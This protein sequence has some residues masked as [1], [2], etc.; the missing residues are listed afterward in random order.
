LWPRTGFYAGVFLAML[1]ALDIAQAHVLGLATG[2]S[3]ALKTAIEHPQRLGLV[4]DPASLS[5]ELIAI[6]LDIYR[7]PAMA[8]AM[9]RLPAFSLGGQAL[10]HAQ[11]QSLQL[12]IQVIAAV[13]AP[14]MFLKNAYAIAELAPPGP[15]GGTAWLRPLGA[16]R[17]AGALQRG[18]HRVPVPILTGR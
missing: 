6:R 1:D 9:P 15:A 10:T 18:E 17:A 2:G 3:V 14:N 13:D 16:V 12:P 11:W 7:Q 5:D 8:D 4:L